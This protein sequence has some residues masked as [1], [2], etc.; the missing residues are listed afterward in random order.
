MSSGYALTNFPNGITSFGI[1]IFGGGLPPFTG[2][3]LFCDYLRGNDGNDGSPNTPLK[4]LSAAYAKTNSGNN[5]VVFIVGDGGTDATQRLT[6]TLAWNNNATH[7]IG[8][9]APTM[10]GQRA[11]ISNLN[12]ATAEINPM[13][14]IGGQGCI[15]ANFSLFQGVGQS[16]TPEQLVQITGLRN[17][18]WRVDF[19]GMGATASTGGAASTTSYCISLSGA[20]ENLFEE[21]NIGVDS[22]ARTVANASV[23]C[24]GGAARN[25][26]K[27]STFLAY[28]TASTPYFVDVSATASIDRLLLFQDCFFNNAVNSGTGTAMAVAVNPSASAGGQV[29][30]DGCTAAGLTAWAAGSTA[31]V[32]VTSS[33]PA[34]SGAGGLATHT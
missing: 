6:A 20:Q 14:S 17:Y 11:R 22:I 8:L 25:I 24:S 2:Q 23:I 32:L 15:F 18:F 28:A 34:T 4:T 13:M 9:T 12:S 16:A 21:C 19:G 30:F 27:K 33:A 3:Y 10:I 5:D 26:F 7:L 29:V 1:P 31:N